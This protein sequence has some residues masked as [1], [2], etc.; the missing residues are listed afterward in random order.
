MSALLRNQIN[1]FNDSL[2]RK[3]LPHKCLPI[4]VWASISM[5]V[6]IY[7]SVQNP[8]RVIADK[9]IQNISLESDN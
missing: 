4:V 1:N 9:K 5:Y 7:S 3:D 2:V 6:N 8:N